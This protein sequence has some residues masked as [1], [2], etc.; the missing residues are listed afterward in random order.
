MLAPDSILGSTEL[1]LNRVYSSK[2]S[3]IKKQQAPASV[4]FYA[5]SRFYSGINGVNP[6]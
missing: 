4:G 2:I 3:K 6:E 1:I 5:C